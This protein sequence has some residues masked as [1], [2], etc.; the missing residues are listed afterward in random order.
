MFVLILLDSGYAP[1]S[2]VFFG[3][4]V[5]FSGYLFFYLK[6]IHQKVTLKN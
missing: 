4:I 6:W 3:V 2:S 5:L 1:D